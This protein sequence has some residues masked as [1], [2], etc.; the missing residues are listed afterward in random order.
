MDKNYESHLAAQ[1][2]VLPSPSDPSAPITGG[3]GIDVD[4]DFFLDTLNRLPGERCQSLRLHDVLRK[5]AVKKNGKRKD[6]T[7]EN[8]LFPPSVID[9]TL[10]EAEIRS[11]LT[12]CCTV[13]VS[14][15]GRERL[16][17]ETLVDGV[18][19]GDGH[20]QRKLFGLLVFMGAGF[21]ARHIFSFPPRGWD[22]TSR[23]PSIRSQLFEPLHQV[24]RNIFTGP[25]KATQ[26]FTS[27]FKQTWQVFDAPKMQI[28]NFITNLDGAN[29]PFINEA[30]LKGDKSAF[31]SLYSFEIHSEF[32]GD[33]VPV[34]DPFCSSLFR[35]H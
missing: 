15:K 23:E 5:E 16:A 8:L 27:V 29:L 7:T 10:V 28:G 33:G 32:R 4:I 2:E 17:D 11:I 6:E 26:V 25:E 20:E 35:I 19:A 22:I 3:T 18:T 9:R 13:C 12:C 31:G 30:P 24:S 34:S 14:V 21:A 1:F